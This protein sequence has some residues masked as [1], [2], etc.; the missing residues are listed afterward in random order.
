[1]S[2]RIA[3]AVRTNVVIWTRCGT[4]ICPVGVAIYDI[5]CREEALLDLVFPFLLCFG[6]L[7]CFVRIGVATPVHGAI[8]RYDRHG[9]DCPF[10]IHGGTGPWFVGE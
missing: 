9:V 3:C 5:L 10:R 4:P 8:R 1:M 2:F 6:V 7:Q